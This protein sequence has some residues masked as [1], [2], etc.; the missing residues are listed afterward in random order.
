MFLLFSIRTHWGVDLPF[1][2][3]MVQKVQFS[4]TINLRVVF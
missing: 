4:V 1:Q 2:E 3:M